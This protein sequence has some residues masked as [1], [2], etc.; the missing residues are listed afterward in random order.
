VVGE[1]ELIHVNLQGFRLILEVQLQLGPDILQMRQLV[2]SI[3]AFVLE[4]VFDFWSLNVR[5][6]EKNM[7]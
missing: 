3:L 2:P 6:S 4:N 7:F 5:I 1:L